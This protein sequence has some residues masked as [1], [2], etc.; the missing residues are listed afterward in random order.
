[1]AGEEFPD[2]VP[3][4]MRDTL[5][6]PPGKYYCSVQAIDGAL[7]GGP[8]ATEA[9]IAKYDTIFASAGVHGTIFRQRCECAGGYRYDVH[10]HAGC[11][12]SCGFS[13]V[14]GVAQRMWQTGEWR[15]RSR[16]RSDHAGSLRRKTLRLTPQDIKRLVN[17]ESASCRS[18]S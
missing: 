8:F 7:A 15:W 16:V 9:V 10:I 5:T 13:I 2:L 17:A 18:A 4:N 12:V 11:R 1:M 3:A 14:D 6:L